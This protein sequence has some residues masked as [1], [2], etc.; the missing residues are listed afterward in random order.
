MKEDQLS[1]LNNEE[2]EEVVGGQFL[3]QP[4]LDLSGGGFDKSKST[5]KGGKSKKQ[6]GKSNNKANRSQRQYC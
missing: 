1:K 5:D 4:I 6:S 3:P 2:L